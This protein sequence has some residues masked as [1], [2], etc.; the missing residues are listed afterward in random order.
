MCR[1]QL[2]VIKPHNVPAHIVTSIATQRAEI[3]KIKEILRAPGVGPA[4]PRHDEYLALY[5]SLAILEERIAGA[6]Q[7]CEGIRVVKEPSASAK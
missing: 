3:R 1:S 4:R 5:R 7:P 6:L 2:A